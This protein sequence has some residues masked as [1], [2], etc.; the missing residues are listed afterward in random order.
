[1]NCVLNALADNEISM[2]AEDILHLVIYLS[3]KLTRVHMGYEY[4]NKT[5]DI[6]T[7]EDINWTL[8][9]TISGKVREE[10]STELNEEDWWIWRF[11]FLCFG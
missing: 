1:M 6:L 2:T 7:S 9:E 3:I 5:K 8:A 10:F 11:S 4:K